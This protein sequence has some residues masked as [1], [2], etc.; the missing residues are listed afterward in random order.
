MLAGLIRGLSLCGLQATSLLLLLWGDLILPCSLTLLSG[1]WGRS[2][3]CGLA[4]SGGGP[5][6][7]HHSSPGASAL[8]S[9]EWE[10]LLVS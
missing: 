9:L 7:P 6:H 8:R 4:C 1:F 2:R 10:V 5:F 3:S